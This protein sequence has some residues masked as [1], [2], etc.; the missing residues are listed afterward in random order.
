MTKRATAAIELLLIFPATLF[1]ATLFERSLQPL[2]YEPAH[3]ARRIV[4]WYAHRPRIGLWLLL[5]ALP[6]AVLI[7]GC[8]TL[9]R[10]WRH[11]V[12][13]HQATRQLLAAIR[14]NLPTL[15]VAGATFVARGILAIVVLHLL[16]D[17]YL[18]R[19]TGV[20]KPGSE[21]FQ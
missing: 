6:F 15:L 8:G 18:R 2:E 1:M 10:S 5:I 12:V 21:T 9:L 13:L 20:S 14:A 7:T 4:M 11:E 3:T 19:D 16:S 17:T